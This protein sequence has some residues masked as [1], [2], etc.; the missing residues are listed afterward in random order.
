MSALSSVA[1]SAAVTSPSIADGSADGNLEALGRRL[2]AAWAYENECYRAADQLRKNERLVRLHKVMKYRENKVDD[3][4]ISFLGE[5]E[6]HYFFNPRDIDD[7][8]G[9]KLCLGKAVDRRVRQLIAVHD[10]EQILEA[11]LGCQE[12]DKRAEKANRETSEIVSQIE[13][14]RATTLAGLMVKAKAIHW[15]HSGDLDF[16]GE[17]YATDSRLMH[18]IV[19]DLLGLGRN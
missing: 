10:E 6:P 3:A 13:D 18:S 14:S 17:D 1:V 9:R 12:A 15:C 11:Q 16:D 7:L 8:R 4:V 5:A 2:D 19:R